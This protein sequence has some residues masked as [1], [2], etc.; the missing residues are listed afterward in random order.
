[1]E[2]IKFE[3]FDN[4]EYKE[5]KYDAEEDQYM[6]FMV[7]EKE[8]LE[9]SIKITM[10]FDNEIHVDV[11]GINMDQAFIMMLKAAAKFRKA[12]DH[13]LLTEVD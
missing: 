9:R 8:V 10:G 4:D 11:N 13:Y 5:E 2:D 1:M 3:S 12:Y 6:N 7:A